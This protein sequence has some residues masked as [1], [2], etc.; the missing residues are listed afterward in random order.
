MKHNSLCNWIVQRWYESSMVRIVRRYCVV[1]HVF[2]GTS[3]EGSIP[4]VTDEDPGIRNSSFT[5]SSVR[6]RDMN[7]RLLA[8]DERRLEAFHMRYQR[9]ITKIR[10]HDHIRNSEVAAR[11]GIGPVS[12]LIT[13]AGTQSSVTLPGFV[14][15]R[16]PTKHSGVMSIWLSAIFLTKAGSVA[17]VVPTTDG[18]TSYA[19]TGTTRHQLTCGEDPPH[20][21]IQEWRYGP[22]RL[23]VDDDDDDCVQTFITPV[24]RIYVMEVWTLQYQRWSP[25]ATQC[26]D[27]QTRIYSTRLKSSLLKHG[28]RWLKEIQ[29]NKNIQNDQN[30]TRNSYP[31]LSKSCFRITEKPTRDCQSL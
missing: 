30:I 7:C 3:L 14:K 17:Q 24:R 5:R 13:R 1:S 11:T 16:Q 21:V 4:L 29:V 26:T 12:D 19:G 23:R 25:L 8:A 20:V 10:G 18:L 15:T 22:R 27:A 2:S 9:Q 28:S 31:G 6:L